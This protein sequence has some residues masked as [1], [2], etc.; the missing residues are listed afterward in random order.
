MTAI[1]YSKLPVGVNCNVVSTCKNKNR[2]LNIDSFFIIEKQL[3]LI[4]I[5]N[6]QVMEKKRMSQKRSKFII[7]LRTV[8]PTLNNL[9]TQTTDGTNKTE[10]PPHPTTEIGNVKI[11]Q[12]KKYFCLSRKLKTTA[13]FR[14]SAAIF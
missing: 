1:R 12:R 6:E 9:Q 10:A 14:R 3:G 7:R 11:S 5:K 4:G 13:R 2:I 8:A